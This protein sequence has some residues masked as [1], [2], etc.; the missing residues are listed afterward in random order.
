MLGL[1]MPEVYRDSY[2]Q[3]EKRE[4]CKELQSSYPPKRLQL[5]LGA[6]ATNGA[7]DQTVGV[8]LGS[9]NLGILAGVLEALVPAEI[10][11]NC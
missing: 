11:A 9:V 1:S 2:V 8:G 4:V 7:L 5:G 3:E 10:C 6:G